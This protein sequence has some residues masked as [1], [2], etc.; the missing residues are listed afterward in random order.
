[1]P[2]IHD[3]ARHAGVSIKTVS[4][5]IN[6]SPSVKPDTRQ[7]VL[8]S[9]RTLDFHAQSWAQNLAR[10]RSRSVAVIIPLAPQ[11]VFSH[12]FFFQ[13]LRGIGEVLELH[14]YELLLHVQAHDRFVD[15]WKERRADA[16]IVMS[17]P[18]RDPRLFELLQAGTPFVATMRV[19]E[20][21]SQLDSAVSWVDSD[22]LGGAEMATDHL[23]SIGHRRLALMN[24]PANL[25]VSHLRAEGFG[26]AL[27]RR[28]LSINDAP[29]LSG[30]F[31][32]ETGRA[33][34]DLLLARPDP[35]TAVFCGDDTLAMGL[36]QAAHGR[37][38]RVPNDLSVVG[39]D[40]MA[41]SS[42]L[43]PPLTT[44]RQPAELKGRLVASTLLRMLEGE[45]PAQVEHHLLPVE[46][47]VRRST[48]APLAMIQEVAEA[49]GGSRI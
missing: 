12:Q 10:R 7:R 13:V 47:V 33:L 21:G 20:P 24:G 35:P 15:L 48:A 17:I 14:G 6:N 4:R 9:I 3:V 41:F 25:M 26:R 45:G 49:L 8:E 44:V 23:L 36:I 29:M 22:H 46:L 34:G 16:L 30:E 38:L 43:D 40:D 18:M 11:F 28:G 1:M 2:N 32:I 19:D 31:S 37:G 39:F 27:R 5:V 42:Y